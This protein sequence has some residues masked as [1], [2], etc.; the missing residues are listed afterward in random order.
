[1]SNALKYLLPM[2]QFHID[3]PSPVGHVIGHMKRMHQE[4]RK[5][6]NDED[7]AEKSI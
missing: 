2:S 1:M 7:A 6:R 4:N 3:I 5:I